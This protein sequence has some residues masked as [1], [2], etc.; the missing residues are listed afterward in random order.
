MLPF[1]DKDLQ[2]QLW[3]CRLEFGRLLETVILPDKSPIESH[4]AVTADTLLHNMMVGHLTDVMRKIRSMSLTARDI[5]LEHHRD[6]S[7]QADFI[8]TF[9]Q[10]QGIALVMLHHSEK[11]EKEAFTD[12]LAYGNHLAALFPGLSSADISYL[13]ISKMESASVRTALLHAQVFDRK[14]VIALI[15][16]Y[17]DFKDK[18]SL[19]LTPWIPD[20]QLI[21][22]LAMLAFKEQNYTILKSK[23]ENIPGWWNPVEGE[24]P[25]AQMKQQMN[26]VTSLVTQEMES[27]GIHG[28]AYTCH[29]WR[30]LDK[31]SPFSNSLIIV[32]LNPYAAARDLVALAEDQAAPDSAGADHLGNLFNS[33]QTNPD[34][35]ESDQQD[36]KSLAMNSS[37]HLVKIAERTLYFALRNITH[38][39]YRI[40]HNLYTG[41]WE[42]F[43]NS[44]FDNIACNKFLLSPTG[45]LREAYKELL[46]SYYA[47]NPPSKDLFY[48]ASGSYS[49]YNQFEK[50][51]QQVLF[52][53]GIERTELLT[54]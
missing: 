6:S 44:V 13:F 42:E 31:L 12:M 51:L 47:E 23:W 49:H 30:E 46:E 41:S 3:K 33:A 25:T 16:E 19:Q 37:A 21:S 34:G 45:F 40:E 5:P 7:L 27:L 50:F 15:P 54:E 9:S 48:F 11:T 28:F 20:T 36:L 26:S 14:E 29:Q 38:T 43:K 52:S 1:S 22:L 4:S 17:T 2:D 39:P 24:E 18:E 35:K 32:A 8:G 53:T 10:Q